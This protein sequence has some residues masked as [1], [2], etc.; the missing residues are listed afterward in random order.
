VVLGDSSP[1]LSLSKNEADAGAGLNQTRHCPGAA[2]ASQTPPES[3]SRR[4]GPDRCEMTFLA[5]MLA[6]PAES[7]VQSRAALI[8]AT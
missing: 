5:L 2:E 7:G 8:A 3:R 1:V 4:A 6:K